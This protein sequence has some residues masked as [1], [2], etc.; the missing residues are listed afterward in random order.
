VLK[1]C[2]FMILSLWNWYAQYDEKFLSN[3]KFCLKI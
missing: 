2:K 1:V 3:L